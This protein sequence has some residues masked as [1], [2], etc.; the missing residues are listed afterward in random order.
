M[1]ADEMRM[2][3]TIILFLIIILLAALLVAAYVITPIIGWLVMN[4]LGGVAVL[5]AIFVLA[6]VLVIDE[7]RED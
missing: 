4:P 7:M 2:M 1:G 3:L 5:I 6:S